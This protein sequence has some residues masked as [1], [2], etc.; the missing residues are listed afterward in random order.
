MLT[1]DRK[2]WKSTVRSR[3][4]H[5]QEWEGKAG[6]RVNEVRGERNTRHVDD[7]FICDWEGCGKVCKSKAGL[8]NHRKRIHEISSQKVMFNCQRCGETFKSEANLKNHIKICTGIH[9]ADPDLRQCDKCQRQ[10]SK[11]NFARHY[12]KCNNQE[13]EVRANIQERGPRYNCPNCDK[14][15]SKSNRARH[16]QTCL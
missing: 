12:R 13:Q 10:I 2:A 11:G 8:T 9:A 5:L 14:N 4:E 7:D 3:A 16:E 1:R 15:L 6:H